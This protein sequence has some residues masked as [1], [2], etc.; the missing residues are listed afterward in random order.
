MVFLWK[1]EEKGK[2]VGRVGVGSGMGTDKGTGKS[3]RTHL[4]KPPFSVLPFSF[5]PKLAKKVACLN[6]GT[7]TASENLSDGRRACISAKAAC[8]F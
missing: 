5:S 3:M 6:W 1:M 2:G 7:G 8:A 4:S